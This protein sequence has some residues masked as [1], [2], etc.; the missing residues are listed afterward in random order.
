MV[1]RL[2]YQFVCR[3]QIVIGGKF[4]LDADFP[5]IAERQEGKPDLRHDPEQG[6]QSQR[7]DGKHQR[8]RI[9]C[10][11]FDA[12]VEFAA[13][14]V[15]ADI[16]RDEHALKQCLP[17][18]LLLFL[19][20][21]QNTGKNRRQG[22]T[23]E[24]RYERCSDHNAGKRHHHAADSRAHHHD[25]HEDDHV[26]QGAGGNRRNH[27]AGSA[28][29]GCLDRFAAVEM[30]E[31]V[32]DHDNRIRYQNADRTSQRKKRHDVERVVEICHDRESHND[33]D[34]H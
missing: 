34:R 13:E 28:F 19:F 11:P 15:I 10:R 1:R 3:V 23:D 33:R 6:S 20:F 18:K 25:G 7:Q 16:P 29:R 9:A 4:E 32:F 31:D 12:L 27:F 5:L 22:E 14:P 17:L 30:L 21:Q 26:G 8:L 24:Q 2:L